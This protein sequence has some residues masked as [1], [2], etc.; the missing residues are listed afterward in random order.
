MQIYW[1]VAAKSKDGDLSISAI[2]YFSSDEKQ[3]KKVHLKINYTSEQADKAIQGALLAQDYLDYKGEFDCKKVLMYLYQT[4]IDDPKA[5]GKTA[6]KAVI[7]T[8]SDRPLPVNFASEL[9]QQKIRS[10][11]DDPKENPFKMGF[12]VDVIVETDRNGIPTFYRV[13][14]VSE[15]I[16]EEGDSEP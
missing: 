12:V 10:I 8:V 2:E 16:R 9:D 6:D 14:N 4:N 1:G 15:I 7:K 11:L 13:F 5:S 3:N